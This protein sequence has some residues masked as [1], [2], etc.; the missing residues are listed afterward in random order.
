MT[1]DKNP[2]DR[3]IPSAILAGLIVFSV[4]TFSL[5]TLP[6]LDADAQRILA[7]CEYAVV[8]IFSVEY[9]YRL[10]TSR[11][12]LK[13]ITSPYGLIDLIAILPFYLSLAID[14]R[15]L[16]VIRLLRLVRLLKLARYSSA[17]ERLAQALR[18]S[19]HELLIS[20]AIL[21]VAIYLSA[22]GIY[23][24]EHAAQPDKFRSIFDALWWSVV[25]IT[26]VG[27][28]DIYPIT[29]GGRLFTFVVMLA[30]LGLVAVPTGIFAT[31][32]LSV[33]RGETAATAERER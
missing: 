30:S 25:T 6:D 18:E 22:F 19:R 31:A 33:K 32:L 12:R 8:A 29:L 16:R 23:Q 27:Y 11:E 7:Y 3:P 10:A 21:G 9:L 14:L 17:F 26:T 24:F 28:G 2:L 4:I 20:T 5:E 1:E 15:S 13:Y